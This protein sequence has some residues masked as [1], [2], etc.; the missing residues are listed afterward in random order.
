[1]TIWSRNMKSKV[2]VK[3]YDNTGFFTSARTEKSLVILFSFGSLIKHIVIC[4]MSFLNEI[5]RNL[6][7]SKAVKIRVIFVLSS[8]PL[9]TFGYCECKKGKW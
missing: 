5:N 4:I 6:S 8:K 3:R 1:M 7:F 2:V 9:A